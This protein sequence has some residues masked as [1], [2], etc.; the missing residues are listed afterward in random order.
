VQAA[1]VSPTEM[2][3]Q[4]PPSEDELVLPVKLLL[5]EHDLEVDTGFTVQYYEE[6]EIDFIY[7]ESARLYKCTRC[8]FSR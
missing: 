1:G 6:L 4:S 3:C 8:H 2:S 5:K 7:P